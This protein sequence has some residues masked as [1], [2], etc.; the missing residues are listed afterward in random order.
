MPA[1]T[2]YASLF[3][4]APSVRFAD[5]QVLAFGTHKWILHTTLP[6]S[7]Y[8]LTAVVSGFYS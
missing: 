8:P 1:E 2:G 6:L 4:P 7:F 5:V 3:I